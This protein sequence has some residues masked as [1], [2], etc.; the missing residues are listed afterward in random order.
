MYVYMLLAHKN[1][2]FSQMSVAAEVW[3]I[4]TEVEKLQSFDIGIM[5]IPG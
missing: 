4:E 3:S 5:P 1:F 2:I